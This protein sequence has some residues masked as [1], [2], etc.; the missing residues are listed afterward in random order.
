MALGLLIAI[1]VLPLFAA[2]VLVPA[3][4]DVSPDFAVYAFVGAVT[5]AVGLIAGLAP[6][7]HGRRG[8]VLARR[9]SF[10]HVVRCT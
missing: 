4:V 6:A 9:S 8:D 7:R 3:G 5:L 10:Q 1:G 2:L